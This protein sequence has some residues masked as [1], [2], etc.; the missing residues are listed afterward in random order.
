[1]LYNILFLMLKS[2][3]TKSFSRIIMVRNLYQYNWKAMSIHYASLPSVY[4]KIHW[5]GFHHEF[6]SIWG[7]CI[8]CLLYNRYE[9]SIIENPVPAP[10][11]TTIFSVIIEHEMEG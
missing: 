5:N 3:F 10:K 11:E 7:A 8:E 9:L 2:S 4:M 6:S 1:M